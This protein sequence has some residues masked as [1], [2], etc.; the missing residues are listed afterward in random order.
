MHSTPQ[1]REHRSGNRYRVDIPCKPRRKRLVSLPFETYQREIQ[2]LPE[3]F[4]V[5]RTWRLYNRKEILQILNE[6]DPNHSVTMKTLKVE[7]IQKWYELEAPHLH[8]NSEG[9]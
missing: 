9:K 7:M 6:L 2:N 8:E 4:G 5:W 1:Y 3:Y